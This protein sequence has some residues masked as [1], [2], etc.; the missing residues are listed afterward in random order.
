MVAKKVSVIGGYGGMGQ[1]FSKFFRKQGLDVVIT[2]PNSRR[3]GEVA[4]KLGV[5]YVKDN[6]E[7]VSD[8]DVVVITV[9]IRK[10]LKVIEEVAPQVKAGALLMDL[11]S[12]KTE[13]YELMLKHASKGVEVLGCHPVFGPRVTSFEGQVFVLCSADKGVKYVWFRGLLQD[14]KAKI[15]ESTAKEHDQVMAVVQGLT[16]FTYISVAETFRRLDFDVKRSREFS[17]PVYDLM[18]D[19][20]GRIAGQDPRLYAEIQMNN[21]HV[22]GV[23]KTYLECALKTAENVEYKNEKA[24]VSDMLASAKH[25]GDVESAMGR[26]DKAINLAGYELK[27]LK[28]LTG[29]RI[30][31][32]HIYTG[33]MHYGVIEYVDA[34]RIVLSDNG[35]K[36]DLK[37]AN[38]RLTST[39]EKNAFRKNKYGLSSRDYSVLIPKH[40]DEERIRQVVGELFDVYSVCVKDVYMGDNIPSNMQSV[41]LNVK[42]FADTLDVVD[43]KVR[44]FFAQ[45]GWNLR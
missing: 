18:L 36:R 21:P 20:I 12:V 16:H 10:T 11:T 37:I 45:M 29:E 31:L 28:E 38:I 30:C 44:G 2:G 6:V 5:E 39:I 7:S 34:D 32:K 27:K 35:V 9:P 23:H 24:F 14:E 15:V 41:C 19:M 25:F 33:T 40:A 3:G 22:V 42:H 4:G 26:S 17:S 43:T 13:P 8:A 1:L